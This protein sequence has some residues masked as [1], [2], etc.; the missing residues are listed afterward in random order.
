MLKIM[1]HVISNSSQF[2]K[3]LQLFSI[4]HCKKSIEKDYIHQICTRALFLFQEIHDNRIPT[5]IKLFRP[6][7]LFLVLSQ[8]KVAG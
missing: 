6:H 5:L 3:V 2:N 8:V 1:I 4:M 7:D